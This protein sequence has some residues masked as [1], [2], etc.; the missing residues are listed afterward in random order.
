VDDRP[1]RD[2]YLDRLDQALP[3][4]DADRVA[5]VEEIE[6]HHADAVAEL[7][8][9]GLPL[10][11]AER[12]ALSR[13]GAPERLAGDLAA[14][15]R[16]PR[17]LLLAAGVALRW[18]VR[19]TVWSVL[20]TWI[21]IFVL[22]L[23]LGLAWA[24]VNRLVPLPRTEW[25]QWI[26]PLLG[27]LTM[28]TAAYAVGRSIVRPV[29]RAAHRPEHGVRVAVLVIGLPLAAWAGL[30]WISLDWNL[31]GAAVAGLL[32]AWFA[33][34]VLRPHLLPAWYPLDRP[35]IGWALIAVILISMAGLSVTG[36]APSG[37]VGADVQP[38]DPATQFAAI[39]PFPAW[40][41]EPL[42]PGS[43]DAVPYARGD[44]GDEWNETWRIGPSTELA[45][46]STV[47]VELWA[48][49]SDPSAALPPG[50]AVVRVLT[51]PL[52]VIGREARTTVAF[53]PLP[54]VAYYYLAV[55]GTDPDGTRE[56]LAWPSFRQWQWDG[57]PWDYFASRLSR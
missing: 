41:Q 53:E 21:M 37:S 18:T 38:M 50:T 51:A 27:A 44:T 54:E 31:L 17:D 24:L 13:L 34:G 56:L 22:A 42:A 30:G 55:V 15:H 46:W 52:A 29:A 35:R 14:A 25:P 48:T 23:A 9:R 57:T 28:A 3:L 43:G 33:L 8:E 12:R 47:E 11:V 4:D 7:V 40:E 26:N 5:A 36:V 39:A 2:V 6:A 1:L 10:D 49:G 45:D 20:V 32:P 19:T 16:T